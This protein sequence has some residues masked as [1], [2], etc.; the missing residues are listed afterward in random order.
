MVTPERERERRGERERERRGRGRGREREREE[1][2][3][4]ER[5]RGQ[6]GGVD[7]GDIQSHVGIPMLCWKCHRVYNVRDNQI[8]CLMGHLK[9]DPKLGMVL[10]AFNPSTWEAEAG[11]FLSSRPAWSTE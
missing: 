1:E 8:I 2:R 10:H 5:K 6:F 4:R 11:G 7:P 9:T 3:K